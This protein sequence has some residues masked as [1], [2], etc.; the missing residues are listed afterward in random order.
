MPVRA[1]YIPVTSLLYTSLPYIYFVHTAYCA[2]CR[3]QD[4]GVAPPKLDRQDGH[5]GGGTRLQ[6][7][8]VAGSAEELVATD[9]NCAKHPG[10]PPRTTFSCPSCGQECFRVPVLERHLQR[11]CSDIINA[12]VLVCARP[13]ASAA[14]Q[15]LLLPPKEF[16]ARS[17]VRQT[18]SVGARNG[19]PRVESRRRCRPCS[20]QQLYGNGC[21]KH[22]WS[23]MHAF[24][25]PCG[26]IAASL[27]D[28]GCGAL[29]DLCTCCGQLQLAFGQCDDEGL[30]IRR[31]HTE[32]GVLLGLHEQRWASWT[33]SPDPANTSAMLRKRFPP[34]VL[35]KPKALPRSHLLLCSLRPARTGCSRVQVLLR[36]A[37]RSVPLVADDIPIDVLYEDNDFVA[38]NKPPGV[39][40][41]PK[42]RYIVRFLFPPPPPKHPPTHHPGVSPA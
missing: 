15:K 27:D 38:V 5:G 36:Q 4:Q 34:R 8:A 7:V 11:C 25:R 42:H 30:P 6:T 33:F 12:E 26:W 31:G 35:C 41:A 21:S 24:P 13:P 39:L 23:V 1:P 20:H 40:T 3:R 2:P 29:D 28:M 18:C 22:E 9:S 17:A 32:L 37:M 10:R 14:S 16:A 19:P